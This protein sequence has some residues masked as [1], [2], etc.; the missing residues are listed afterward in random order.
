MDV[1]L[2]DLRAQYR[3]I[4]EE[5]DAAVANVFASQH[6]IL[7]PVVVE[8]ETAVAAYSNCD[9]AVGVSSGSDAL[10]VALMAEG[11]GAGDE[12]IT[13]PYTFFATAGAVTR[14]GA[15]PVFVDIDP[16]SFN[17]D[18]TAI[19][20][21]VTPRCKAIIP[22]HLYGRMADMDPVMQVARDHDLVVIEDAAQAIGAEYNGR[23]AGSIGDYGC[24]SFFPSKNLG[25][26]GDGG[27][28]VTNDAER[29]ERLRVLRVHGG[30]PKYYHRVIGGNFRLDAIQ[31]AVVAVKL[32]HL[33]AWTEARQQNARR[34][35]ALFA[36]AGLDG[37][38]TTPAETDDRHIYNQYVLRVDSR[39]ALMA[40]LKDAGIGCEIYYPVPLHRQECFASLGHGEGDFPESERAARETVAIPVYPEL[41]GDQARYVVET[42][43]A[44]Y[45]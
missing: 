21:A 19:A 40:H 45:N 5:V 33:D 2:L 12:V 1:P 24:L 11:I 44:F 18:V 9:H 39:D 31:A 17:M 37:Q 28:V 20:A 7:G 3:S 36:Q 27:M 29:A 35:A 42:I 43:T 15:T 13:T 30:N 41:S 32:R 23:R 38:V 4:K 16:E 6:F 10:L 25:G 34:Y 26:A 8:C 14:L 22:I